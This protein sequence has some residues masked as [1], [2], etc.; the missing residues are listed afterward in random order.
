MKTVEAAK[1]GFSAERLGRVTK[2]FE[3]YI[4]SGFIA[5]VNGLIARRG[6]LVFAESVGKQ[7]LGEA[8][9]SMESLFRIYSMTK[10]VTTVAA[11]MLYEEAKFL[12]D[13]P[14]STYLPY[15]ADTKVCKASKHTGLELEPQLQPMTIRDLMMHTAGLSYGWYQDT[16][17]D[18][19]YRETKVNPADMPLGDF[20]ELLADM[21]LVF[22]PG[23]N[24]RYS[25]ATDVLGHL[26]QVIADESLESFMQRRI[27]EP[28]GMTDT[29]FEAPTEKLERFTTVY[30]PTE[31]FGFGV[32]YSTLAKDGT[33]Y[34]IDT[35]TK[36]R[37]VNHSVKVSGMSGGGGLVSTM[38]DYLCF[39]QMLLNKGQLNG[40]QI[41]GRKTVELMRKNHVPLNIRPLE[42]GGNAMPGI[43][44]GLGVAVVEDTGMHGILGSKGVF[45]WSGA[46]MTSFWIDPVE[47]LIGIMMTQFMPN[48]FYRL[49][50]EFRV[51]S[52]QALVD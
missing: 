43:G 20:V 33:I 37:F 31:E 15:F 7:G 27:F 48:D 40:V 44:F 9:M 2:H 1:Q 26:V 16:P 13:D 47:D 24:W 10:P 4:D 30:C 42:I 12:L 38:S 28:L 39:A 45:A 22:Q 23:T 29:A 8:A 51:L 25:H 17:V 46:A 41:L 52:Y 6:E 11:L 19:L 14:V 49:S 50:D 21:P 35:P 5:G 36:S 32:D 18:G 3:Q 34:P